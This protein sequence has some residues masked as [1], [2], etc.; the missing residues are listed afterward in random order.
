M[1]KLKEYLLSVK[2][3]DER[4]VSSIDTASTKVV[5]RLAY[6]GKAEFSTRGLVIGYVQSG[7]T[8]NFTATI[9]KAA[10]A[11][12]KFFIVLSGLTN[13]L[14]RQTQERLES[15]LSSLNP[16]NWFTLTGQD[17]DFAERSNVNAFLAQHANYKLLCVMKKHPTRLRKLLKWLSGASDL[18]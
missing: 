7:K 6:P 16:D 5:S 2:K 14:R 9:A 17:H 15:E 18:T 1:P 3:W 4:T 13:K 10:D 8:A 12:Y 11:R